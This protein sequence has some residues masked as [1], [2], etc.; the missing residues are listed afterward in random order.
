[1][2]RGKDKQKRK[3]RRKQIGLGLAAGTGVV[4][5]AG[6]AGRYGKAALNQ[7]KAKKNLRTPYVGQTKDLGG[8]KAL[9]ED[10][11]GRLNRTQ[12]GVR[13][14]VSGGLTSASRKIGD[15]SQTLVASATELA[16]NLGKKASGTRVG[17]ELAK[18][19]SYAKTGYLLGRGKSSGLKGA[20][21]GVP[22]AI[23]EGLSTRGGK[24]LAA[25]GVLAAG[26]AG[27]GVYNLLRN[28]SK[29][30]R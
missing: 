13:S 25:V 22:S 18:T 3:S 6:V 24:G 17:K 27:A 23:R 5:T 21:K 16:G 11:L 30:R 9:L 14:A 4:G 12:M 29:S 10:D 26:G 28:R 7:G 20:A 2:G 19:R 1:M 15:K 8:A